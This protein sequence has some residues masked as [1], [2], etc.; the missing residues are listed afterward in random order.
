MNLHIL[1]LSHCKHTSAESVAQAVS[2]QLQALDKCLTELSQTEAKL[3]RPVVAVTELAV[4]V[5]QK[6]AAS[7]REAVYAE[8]QA[9]LAG[10]SHPRATS[11]RKERKSA[12]RIIVK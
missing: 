3:G 1:T 4:K 6:A 9:W 7:E 8:A 2:R 5:A 12:L 11:G 10:L